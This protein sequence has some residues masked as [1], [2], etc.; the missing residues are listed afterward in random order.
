MILPNCS[1][2][3]KP[4]VCNVEIKTPF[5]ILDKYFNISFGTCV[6]SN[7]VFG[8]EGERE[9]M[10][11]FKVYLPVSTFLCGLDGLSITLV[12]FRNVSI[13]QNVK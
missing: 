6:Q 13:Q 7:F 4:F 5:L 11:D 2:T 1:Q 10:V 12:Q 3:D 9:G 8:G